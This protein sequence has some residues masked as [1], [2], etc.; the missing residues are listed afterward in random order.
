VSVGGSDAEAC[1]A[2]QFGYR[3]VDAALPEKT[4][5]S[6]SEGSAAPDGV[7]PGVCPLRCAVHVPMISEKFFP[8]RKLSANIAA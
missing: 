6:I 5:D 7:T 4:F 2:G 1:L 3:E 8:I